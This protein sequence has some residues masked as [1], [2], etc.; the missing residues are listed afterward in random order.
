MRTPRPEL[1]AEQPNLAPNRPLRS[2]LE[3]SNLDI[4][5]Q[6]AYPNFTFFMKLMAFW[7]LK[8]DPETYSFAQMVRD[9][10]TVWDG[11]ANNTAQMH[12]RA[13]KKGDKACIYHSGDERAI[14]GLASVDSNAYPD[15]KVPGTKLHVVELKTGKLLKDPV[16][17]ADIKAR[18]E[19]A[20]FDL[21]RISRLSVMPVPPKL[22]DL[23]MKM[24]GE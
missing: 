21:L 24:A 3:G 9:Q 6:F 12:I 8:T 20:S 23:L 11:V 22:W 2:T 17:L 19:F 14:V 16:T 4:L 10:H 1:D 18:K 15:P 7:L 5:A 13:M